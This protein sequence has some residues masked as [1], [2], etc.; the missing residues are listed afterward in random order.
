LEWLKKTA[1]FKPPS[2]A[3]KKSEGAIGE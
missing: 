2:A 1:T 3:H